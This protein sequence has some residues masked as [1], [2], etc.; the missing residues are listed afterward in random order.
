MVDGISQ[1]P[2]LI[3][4]FA[5]VPSDHTISATFKPEIGTIKNY[6]LFDG[7]NTVARGQVLEAYKGTLS[8]DGVGKV[9]LTGGDGY[10][11]TWADDAFDITTDSGF[12][13]FTGSGYYQGIPDITPILHSGV[14]QIT[15]NVRDLY[16]YSI[17]YHE[18]WVHYS[19]NDP[20][21][22][23]GVAQPGSDQS[24]EPSPSIINATE[25]QEIIASVT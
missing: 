21:V 22:L 18:T 10:I 8:W 24:T 16:A 19:S 23:M 6:K 20:P 12:R 7:F 1:K 25:T 17:G 2:D 4:S 13:T 9:Y 3:Y 11:N 15:I 14:N 5:A